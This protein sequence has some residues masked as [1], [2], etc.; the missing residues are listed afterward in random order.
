MNH[1]QQAF[2]NSVPDDKADEILT[3]AIAH[4]VDKKL[5]DNRSKGKSG[6]H[7]SGATTESLKKDLKNCVGKGDMVDAMILAGMIHV[8]E[9]MVG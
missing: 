7:T 2:I 9:S 3:S 8:R 6:W 1:F 4:A 5:A